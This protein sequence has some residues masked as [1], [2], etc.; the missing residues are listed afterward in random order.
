ML[1]TDGTRT[2]AIFLYADG[3]IQWTTGDDQGGVDGLGGTPAQVGFNNGDGVNFA[4]IPPSGTADVL[5]LDSSSNINMPGTWIFQI[6]GDTIPTVYSKNISVSRFVLDVMV[7]CIAHIHCIII[8]I[9]CY[10][11]LVL[12]CTLNGQMYQVGEQCQPNCTSRCTCEAGG[13]FSCVTVPC[14]IDGP[15]CGGNGDPHYRTFDQRAHHFQGRCEY[16]LTKPCTNND[17]IITG[18][19]VGSRNRRV[20]YTAAV[21]ISRPSQNLNILL[22]R[23]TPTHRGGTVTINGVL[24]QST[25]NGP[26]FQSSEVDVVRIGGH[27]HVFLNGPGLRVFWDGGSTVRV[28]AST[29]LQNQLCGLLGTYNGD[30]SDDFMTPDGRVVTS[31]NE[32]GNSWLVPSNTPGCTGTTI[33]TITTTTSLSRRDTE[34]RNALGIAPSIDECTNDTRII[35]EGRRRCSVLTQEAFAACNAL[36]DPTEFIENCEFDYCCSDDED[37]E[38]GYCDNLGTYAAACADVAAISSTW[39]QEFCRKSMLQWI[40]VHVLK[41]IIIVLLA[42]DCPTGMVYHQCGTLCPQT[43]ENIGEV[44]GGGCASGCFCPSGQVLL[45]GECVDVFRCTG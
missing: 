16:V 31:V 26:I 17:F 45:E 14:D 3:L 34:K 21:T 39:R 40:I 23:Q 2:Y 44:C 42:V 32:F 5:N 22:G 35:E 25:R 36:I 30:Q 27:P 12:G 7:N 15:T 13:D 43:C 33:T 41:T 1:A 6:D 20:S 18:I 10:V 37:R 9:L 24:Q 11:F 28:T 4:V 8:V 19:N 38:D 29:F